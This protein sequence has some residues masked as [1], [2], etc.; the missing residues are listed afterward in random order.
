MKN[1][2]DADL[3]RWC[4][5]LAEDKP[6][7]QVPEGWKTVKQLAEDLGKSVTATKILV[8]LALKRGAVE[9]RR[10]RVRS[11]QKVYPVTHYKL[12]NEAVKKS[13]KVLTRPKKQR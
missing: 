3:A 9:S 10:Y 11:A 6:V 8:A 2:A 13:K 12:V 4:E 1:K 7:D 5:V